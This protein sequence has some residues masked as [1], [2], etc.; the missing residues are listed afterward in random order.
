MDQR[1]CTEHTYMYVEQ[2]NTGKI[3]GLILFL[4]AV[5]LS[6][7][8]CYN[9]YWSHLWLAIS[10]LVFFNIIICADVAVG[11]EDSWSIYHHLS[12]TEPCAKY[13]CECCLAKFPYPSFSFKVVNRAAALL[14]V[15]GLSFSH[16]CWHSPFKL[17]KHYWCL[18]GI[19]CQLCISCSN[20][21]SIELDF[22]PNRSI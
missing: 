9:A 11:V 4:V 13:L 5:P 17:W 16:S 21:L 22:L 6:L 7:M 19:F 14:T 20:A 12:Q 15:C 1:V 3:P 2:T 8:Y 10:L 18:C